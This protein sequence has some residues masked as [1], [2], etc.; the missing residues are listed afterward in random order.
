MLTKRQKLFF[1]VLQ[2]LVRKKGYFPTVREIGKE[3]GLSSP[4]TVQS[5]LNKL[6]EKGYLDK[7]NRSWEFEHEFYKIPLVG[8]VPAGSPLEIFESLGEEVEL[9]EWMVERGG[10]IVGFRVQGESMKDAFIREGD[11]V[12]VKRVTQANAGDMVVALLSDSSI[13]LKRL[14]RDQNRVWLIPENPDFEPIFE[15]FQLVGKVISVLRKY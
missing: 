6:Y 9:P 4:A 3:M 11:I 13:T 14:K 10:Q 15:P 8:I 7:K 1:E 5:Y 12:V 2:E